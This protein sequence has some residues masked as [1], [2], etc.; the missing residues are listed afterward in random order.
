MPNQQTPYNNQTKQSNQQNQ[1]QKP[2]GNFGNKEN[3]MNR[4]SNAGGPT[5]KQSGVN[6][7]INDRNSDVGKD[8]DGDGRPVQ[9]GHRA[10]EIDGD[11][12]NR[13]KH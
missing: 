9:P 2:A 6:A 10:G 11:R 12:Q 13:N 5:T 4:N 7:R 8:T 1:N 3:E